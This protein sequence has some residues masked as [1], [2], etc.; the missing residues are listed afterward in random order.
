V[1]RRRVLLGKALGTP[2]RQAH[3]P[4]RS[5]EALAADPV[6]LA[7]DAAKTGSLDKLGKRDQRVASLL[8]ARE[9]EQR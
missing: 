8:Q 7:D 3:A 5:P 9:L 4:A 6:V 2:Q 1:K